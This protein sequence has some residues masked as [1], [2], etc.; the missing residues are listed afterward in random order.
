MRMY[1]LNWFPAAATAALVDMD[2]FPFVS[3][4]EEVRVEEEEECLL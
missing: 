3:E 2:G 1:K 4:V